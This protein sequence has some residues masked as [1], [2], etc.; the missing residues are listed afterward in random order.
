LGKSNSEFIFNMIAPVYGLFYNWQKKRF[1]EVIDAA[2][3]TMDLD[4]FETI[5]DIGCGT[6]AL[7][8]ALD[9]RGLLVTGVDTA[10]KMLNIGR[11][12]LENKAVNFILGNALEKLPFEDKTFDVSIASYVAHGMG[13]KER[14]ILYQEMSRVT[15][16]KVIIYDYNQK[17]SILV[18]IIEWFEQGDYFNFIKSAEKEMHRYF[19]D[20][21]VLNVTKGAAWYICIPVDAAAWKK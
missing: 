14:E 12:K 2:K 4:S 10:E 3:G 17:R 18:S 19:L 8:S 9:K 20:V 7:C 11:H 13:Q 15:K 5:L 16:H 21:S 6:G 1:K